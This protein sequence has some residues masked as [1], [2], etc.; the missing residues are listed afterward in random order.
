MGKLLCAVV[1]LMT[2][3]TATAA[4]ITP[5]NLVGRYTVEA[6]V[7]FRKFYAN[8]R[9]IDTKEFEIQRTYSDG[10]KDEVCNGTYSLA[11]A[12]YLTVDDVLAAGKEFKG[13]FTCPSN[14]SKTMTF[15]IDFE[16][17]K[18]EDLQRGTQVSVTSSM[19]PGM[20]ANAYLK[21][22]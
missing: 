17:K 10:A 19:A 1:V 6:R 4:E 15:N 8:V 12:F 7:A 3:I 14:R 16:N 2:S 11:Q 18:M 9:I 13:T 5:G 22:Q 21:K 20:R